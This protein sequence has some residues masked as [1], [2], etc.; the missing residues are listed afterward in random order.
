MQLADL[1]RWTQ[2]DPAKR[3]FLSLFPDGERPCAGDLGEAAEELAT[4]AMSVGVVTGFFVPDAPLP[5]AET[6]G[7]T[8]SI[9]L[10]DVLRSRSCDVCLITDTLCAPVV[11]AALDAC[12]I[13][14]EL[15]VSPVS[16]D[17]SA[18][19]RD[20][21][22]TSGHGARLTHLISVE[23]IGPGACELHE[24]PQCRNMRGL[25]IDR[26]SADLYR[27]FEEHPDGVRTIG[28][29]DGGNE[30]GMGRCWANTPAE[31]RPVN[32]CRTVTDWTVLA[33]VSDWGAMALAAA[34]VLQCGDSSPLDRWTTARIEHAL[35]KM[36]T[37]GPAIDG[38]TFRPEP[39]VDGLPFATYI[40][41][42][43][44]IRRELGLDRR[45]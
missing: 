8:G 20:A 5:S 15:D 2:R 32:A 44:L 21:F 9:L 1:E 41:P 11:R 38:C 31:R 25:P 13:N 28:I 12:G 33:G 39:T 42:W 40:Q 26:W 27:L 17:E 43:D 18:P 19:W 3:G 29:G 7:P 6:D 36:V 45:S 23:R 10:A 4:R 37:D 14:I 30:I 22:W 16:P 24:I 34:I 35:T